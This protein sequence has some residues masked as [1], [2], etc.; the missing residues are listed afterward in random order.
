MAATEH[1]LGVVLAGGRSL[2]MGRDKALLEWNGRTLLD[3]AIARFR[4]AGI[5]RV[6]VSGD[7]PNYRCIV[8]IVPQ[9]GPL[10]GLYAVARAYPEHVLVV[11]PV[12]MP[13]LPA[14]WLA[15][16]VEGVGQDVALHFDSA[17]LPF[18]VRADARILQS[19]HARICDPQSSKALHSWLR[20]IGARAL[21]RPD[22]PVDGFD[23][24]N[25]PAEWVRMS[26]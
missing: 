22:D 14:E 6:I 9:A 24:V 12:D 23:N 26:P 5:P 20:D 8:D 15:T 1:L 13:T 2:R 25:T 19:L 18:A 17:P 16:L 7:R 3:H 21:P 11:V 4:L 10:G